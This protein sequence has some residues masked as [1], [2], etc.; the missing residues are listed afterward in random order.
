[1]ENNYD[2]ELDFVLEELIVDY[3]NQFKGIKFYSDEYRKKL[4]DEIGEKLKIRFGLKDWEIDLLYHNLFMDK[5]IKSVDSLS[6]SLDGLVFR[7]NG[8]Y[9][10]RSIRRNSE[11]L[12]I[13]KLEKSTQKN[14]LGLVIFT[15]LLAIGT[16]ISAWYFAIEIWR[17]Y[18]SPSLH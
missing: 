12:R 9:T 5:Y 14:A 11:N 15:A 10:G 2:T 17:Y 13:Q 1:M 4:N 8:G 7:N 18:Y 6:I 3:E 16:L